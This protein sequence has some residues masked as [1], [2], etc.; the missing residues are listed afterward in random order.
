MQSLHSSHLVLERRHVK[1]HLREPLL[2]GQPNV[3][4]F[5]SGTCEQVWW[6]KRRNKKIN[7]YEFFRKYIW[8]SVHRKNTIAIQHIHSV[9]G[10]MINKV[11]TL[12]RQS[13]PRNQDQLP[14]HEEILVCKENTTTEEVSWPLTH[15]K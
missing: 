14:L 5:R 1:R 9:Q 6:A 7:H 10:D 11:L 12:Y 15:H 8:W 13:S 2:Q 3:C 4:M